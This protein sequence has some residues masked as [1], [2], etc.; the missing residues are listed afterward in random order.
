MSIRETVITTV[1]AL[2]VLAVAGN[3]VGAIILTTDKESYTVGEIVHL[4]ATNVGPLP[5]QFVSY[6]RF[7][8]FNTD[9]DECVYGCLGLPVVEP[10]PVGVTVSLDWDT[11]MIPDPPGNYRVGLSA[12]EAPSVFYVLTDVVDVEPHSWGALKALYR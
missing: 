10:F 8:I 7:L 3:A 1:I 6:P 5:T 12:P 9:T 4:E 11:G 2:L